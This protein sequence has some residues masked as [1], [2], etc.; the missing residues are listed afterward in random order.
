MASLVE[1]FPGVQVSALL[2]MSS[3]WFPA[4]GALI[5]GRDKVKSDLQLRPLLQFWPLA[6]E[7]P[8]IFGFKCVWHLWPLARIWILSGPRTFPALSQERN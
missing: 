4:R 8:E 5:G 1:G 2:V 7:E 3:L 6:T